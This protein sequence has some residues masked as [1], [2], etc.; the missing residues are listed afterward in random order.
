M[1]VTM[2]VT[3]MFFSKSIILFCPVPSNP[4]RKGKDWYHYISLIIF[5]I[6]R[7]SFSHVQRCQNDTSVDVEITLQEMSNL[8]SR[9]G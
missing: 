3:A 2:Q 7:V 4:E 9:K 5:S 1:T 6:I 8:H